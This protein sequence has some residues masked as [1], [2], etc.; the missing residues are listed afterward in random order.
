MC[1]SFLYFNYWIQYSYIFYELDQYENMTTKVIL[2][3]TITIATW[4]MKWNDWSWFD[5]D[6]QS[7]MTTTWRG[8]LLPTA[9]YWHVL[10]WRTARND[11]AAPVSWWNPPG[12]GL[13]PLLPLWVRCHLVLG[14]SLLSIWR[15]LGLRPVPLASV[16]STQAWTRARNSYKQLTTVSPQDP[17]N[18]PQICF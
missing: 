5:I 1:I 2:S 11:W 3:W 6:V 8:W 10:P 13:V 18:C 17:L 4:N 16:M 14:A 15:R 7:N 12:P 9:G